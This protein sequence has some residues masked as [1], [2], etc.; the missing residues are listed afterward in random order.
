MIDKIRNAFDTYQH[1]M[2]DD[3]AAVMAID[4][5]GDG[6]VQEGMPFGEGPAK[7]LNCF[8]KIAERMG[9]ETDNV[10]NYAGV[11]SYGSG[12]ETVGV[13]AHLD[14]V[15]AGKGWTV[16]PFKLTIKD[17]LMYGR[18][19]MDDKGSAI[20]ALYG[21]S[22]IRDLGIPLKRGLKLVVGTN[23]ELGSKC[24]EYYVAHREPPTLG[25]TPDA[26]YPLIHGE[27]GSFWAKLFFDKEELPILKMEAGEVFN[28]VPAECT[29]LLNSSVDADALKASAE[30]GFSE[31]Y[32]VTI[33]KTADGKI[34]MV[35][36]GKAAHGSM[37]Y[38]GVNAIV[39]TAMILC[40]ALGEKAGKLLH[41][42]RDVIGRDPYGKTAGVYF[43]DDNGELTLNLGLLRF[44]NGEGWIGTDIRFPVT[45][46][47]AY[48]AG[49]YQ[50]MAD[51]YGIRAEIPTP[52]E[53]HFVPED[54][55]LVT[56]L[57]QVY[58]EVTG[59]KD[60]KSMTIGGGT[61]AR[62]VGKKFVAFGPEFGDTDYHMH[63]ADEFY[64]LE[65]YMKHCVICTMAMLKLAE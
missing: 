12:A 9:L 53:P 43:K 64:P 49:L 55:E 26:S 44:E 3:L 37:P 58:R 7:A 21:L 1:Q 4:S 46:T 62:H 51:K 54:S 34:C 17:G 16:D 35:V 36:K 40:D 6:P 59:E 50:A 41:F 60:A 24:M 20:A 5:S 31:G 14:V 27:K 28:A 63:N 57:L 13:L 65:D 18:G 48:A 33:E 19:V 22:I 42:V 15:P 25:F 8:L 61:Y 39:S 23:E 52:S 29:V 10:D 47:G 2:L 38:L 11:V 45:G 56:T 30:K 32:P